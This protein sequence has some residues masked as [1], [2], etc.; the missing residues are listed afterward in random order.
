MDYKYGSF[1]AVFTDGTI[2][3]CEKSTYQSFKKLVIHHLQVDLKYG[4]INAAIIYSGTTRNLKGRALLSSH[5]NY[6][7]VS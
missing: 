7:E 3:E 5:K 1:H 4:I 6:R 2:I